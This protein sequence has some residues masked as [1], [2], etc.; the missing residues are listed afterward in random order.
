MGTKM[1]YIL[2]LPSRTLDFLALELV[3]VSFLATEAA[4]TYRIVLL[5]NPSWPGAETNHHL[6]VIRDKSYLSTFKSTAKSFQ[7]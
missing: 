6:N 2:S 5:I 4:M 7:C 1:F 3:I